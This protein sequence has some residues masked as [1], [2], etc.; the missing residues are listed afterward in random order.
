MWSIVIKKWSLTEYNQKQVLTSGLKCV[1]N[2][3]WE[4]WNKKEA[5]WVQLKIN[6]EFLS[7]R[8]DW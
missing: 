2:E 1:K 4:G 5:I 8:K 6:Y 7:Q 3:T